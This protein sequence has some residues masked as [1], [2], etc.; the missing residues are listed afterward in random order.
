MEDTKPTGAKIDAWFRTL[1]EGDKLK[2]GLNTAYPGAE[3][4]VCVVGKPGRTSVRIVYRDGKSSWIR[5]PQTVSGFVEVT[6]TKITYYID[7][8]G[9]QHTATWEKV[10]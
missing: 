4:G 8:R 7:I 1:K 10:T 9:S 6:D 3:R 2:R 5:P